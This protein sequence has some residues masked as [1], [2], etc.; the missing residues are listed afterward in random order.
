MKF[1]AICTVSSAPLPARGTLRI[2]MGGFT[3]PADIDF[4]VAALAA[5][6]ASVALHPIEA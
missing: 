2:G 1:L 3:S 5:A 4:A 6:H